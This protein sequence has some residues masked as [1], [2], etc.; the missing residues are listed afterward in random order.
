MAAPRALGSSYRRISNRNPAKKAIMHRHIN[1]GS[2]FA[3]KERFD[4][5]CDALRRGVV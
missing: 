2:A 5:A 3:V 1:L 4:E